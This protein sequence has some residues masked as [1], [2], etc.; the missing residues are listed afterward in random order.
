MGKENMEVSMFFCYHFSKFYN[1]AQSLYRINLFKN[2]GHHILEE[3][4]TMNKAPEE[5][6]QEREKRVNDA[7]AL[8]VPDRV[9]VILTT[10]FYDPVYAGITQE[11]FMMDPEKHLDATW[12][13]N[14]DFAPDLANGPLLVGPM[15]EALDYKQLR[16]P[17]HGLPSD[18]PYQYVEGEY[19]KAEEYDDLIFDPSDFTVRIIWPRIF[20]NLKAFASMPPLSTL[21]G[22]L[23]TGWGFTAFALPG[24]QEAFDAM[25]KAGEETLKWFG[26]MVPFLMKLRQA[27]FPIFLGAA[28][29]AP[30]DMLGDTLRGTKG[31]MTDMYRRP[32]KV[33]AA[34]EKLLPI[35]IRESV[36]GARM[37]GNPRVFIP[38]HKGSEGF[39]SQEQFKRFYWPTLRALIIG[40]VDEGL[41]PVIFV[42]GRY[43]ARLECLRDVPVGKVLYL[44]ED[45][46]MSKAKDVLGDVACIMGNVPAS[47]MVTGTPDQVRAYCKQLIDTAGKGG[48]YIM[49]QGG[50]PENLKVENL[51][52][53]VDFTRE[54]GVY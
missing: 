35:K 16:W 8:K 48:G 44:F 2:T 37:S 24:G 23:T 21:M 31:I 6:Y 26:V 50:S 13:V 12:K 14:I 1:T 19:M 33:I 43:E 10:G 32:D 7:I 9:P 30:F 39:M 51:R 15:F 27:G 4:T 40:L 5:L 54:Y 53:M 11:E 22:G 45:T 36:M 3:Y 18:T 38:L 29:F 42:E 28:T 46:D 49:A 52:A 25:K 41:T 20:G 34:C 47:L 17:G